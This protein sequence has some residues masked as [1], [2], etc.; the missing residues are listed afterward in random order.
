MSA[1]PE[2]L[3][4]VR[5]LVKRFPVKEGIFVDRTVDYVDAVSGVSFDI[6]AGKTLGLVGESGS[7]KSTTGYCILQ[8]LQPTSGSVRFDGRELTELGRSD[9]RG[10]RRELQIVFQ[11]PYSS[12]DPRMTV[13]DIVGEPLVVHKVGSRR[14][15]RARVRELLDVVGF[16]PSYVNRY[17][18]EFSGGQRQRIGIARALALSPRLIVCDEP[19]SALDVSIQAQ[20]INLLK[21]LQARVRARVPLHRAR[22]RGRAFRERPHRRHAPR[23][24]RRERAGG[25]GLR[26]PEGGVHASAARVGPGARPGADAVPQ[27]RAATAARHRRDVIPLALVALALGLAA[28]SLT[29]TGR[30]AE[31]GWERVASL[32]Q[33]RSY[34]AAAEL[35]GRIYAAG[36]MVGETGRPLAT[37][38]RYEP[39]ADAWE[40]LAPLPEPTRAAAAATWRGRVVVAGGTTAA[41]NVATVRSLDARRGEWQRLPSL[42][43]PRFNHELVSLAGK[44]YALGGFHDG[45]ER[46]DVF[47]L[48]PGGN[49]WR[50]TTPLPSPTH[51]FGAV[52]FRGR[53]WVV[54]GRRGERV[55]REV[56]VLDPRTERWRRGP[57]LPR[58]ME[59]LGLAVRDDELH[60][61]W[62]STYQVYD[63]GAGRWR[64]GPR[65]GRDASRAC[66]VRDRGRA[67]HGRRLHDCP[68]RQPG[69][70]A[71]RAEL[72]DAREG[73]TT[74]GASRSPSAAPRSSPRRSRGSS[75][76]GRGAR[77]GTRP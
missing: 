17:P 64:Q 71:A 19:V 9:L 12:L 28:G 47:V 3:L 42:P 16:D 41:G 32:S 61:V 37:V 26:E 23:G 4:Q 2:P 13:G 38:S 10:V 56:W 11:D 6:P 72:T 76:R 54:G 53:L 52:A 58:P 49:A 21:E 5:D 73:P 59:L 1:S 68:A 57:S 50:R 75:G 35:G 25:D 44:L 36:G 27:G 22:P 65:P 33:R 30:S 8:L 40:T 55:L 48:G 31:S 7:G 62:E 18:H 60:A 63:A 77:W 29:E 67:L 45:R 20:I 14:D 46:R 70:G 66:G 39:G 15:R 34:I 74:P 51:A 69:R 43:E 24:D